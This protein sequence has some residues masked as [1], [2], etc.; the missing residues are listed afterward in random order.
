MNGEEEQPLAVGTRVRHVSQ[1]WAT[2]DIWTAEIT[3]VSNRW[4]DGTFEYDVL[5]GELFA[6]RL[7]ETN[8]MTRVTTWSSRC[9]IP[10]EDKEKG[11]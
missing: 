4:W 7:S 10:V 11:N 9:T 2:G 1:Q 6:C 5:A 3:R 8:P